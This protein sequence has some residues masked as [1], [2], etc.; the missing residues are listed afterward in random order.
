MATLAPC[1][2]SSSAI[3]RPMRFAAP[4]TSAVVPVNSLSIE[5]RVYCRLVVN[6][7]CGVLLEEVELCGVVVDAGG[8]AGAGFAGCVGL[9]GSC[10]P[11]F[12]AAA[13]P[14]LFS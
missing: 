14:S 13:L 8:E 10:T 4:V 6:H 2:A 3:A 11:G 12:R 1:A 9:I 7:C 5:L